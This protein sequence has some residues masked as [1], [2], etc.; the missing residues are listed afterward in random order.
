MFESIFK[1][2]LNSNSKQS[3]VDM[4]FMI[5]IYVINKSQIQINE[6]IVKVT[7]SSK[8]DGDS[9]MLSNCDSECEF[10]K[11]NKEVFVKH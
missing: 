2:Q 7:P 6:P 4:N 9:D 3:L 5:I 10:L 1:Y 8:T 11:T